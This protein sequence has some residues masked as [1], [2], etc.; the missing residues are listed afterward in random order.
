MAQDNNHPSG[1]VD[2]PPRLTRI[3][4]SISTS[5]DQSMANVSLT[6]GMAARASAFLADRTGRSQTWSKTNMFT[7]ND[8]QRVEW[9]KSLSQP[10]LA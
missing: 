10:G 4:R 8:W 5:S 3:S 6:Y 1:F 9:L 7:I 2:Q